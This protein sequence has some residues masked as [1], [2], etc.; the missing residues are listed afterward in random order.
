MSLLGQLTV[1]IMGSTAGYSGA[2]TAAQKAT[3]QFAKGIE[4]TGRNVSNFGKSLS[5]IG[6]SL[7]KKLTLPAVGAA[8]AL[9][10]ITLAKGWNRLVGIDTAKAKLIGLGHDADGVSKIMESALE[11]VKG[12]S[13]GM[14]EAATTAAS[15]VAAGIAPGKELTRYLSLTG[16]A[17]AIAGASMS[18]MGSIFN[19]V[20][21]SNKAYNDSLGQLS[22][23]GLPIYQ[24][25]AK[26][27]GVTEEAV[28]KM[29][30]EGKVS[31]EMFQAAIENNI[32]GAAK[33]MGENSF[34]ASLANMW[35]SVGR[36]G[37]N[38]LDAGG[39]GGGFFSTIKPMISDFTKNLGSIEEK[40]K[41]IGTKFG[42][43]FNGFITKIQEI[44]AKFDGLSPSMQDFIKKTALISAG[45]LVGIGP[46]IGIVGKLIMGIGGAITT[47]GKMTG[48]ISKLSVGIKGFGATIGFLTSPIGIA[49][50]SIT[51]LITI[52]V[53]LY[54]NWDTIK[55]KA[56]VV[57]TA[58]APL[59]ETVKGAFQN[60]MSSLGPIWESMKTLFESLL[61]ILEMVGIVVGGVIV[62]AFGIAISVFNAVVS[63]IGPLIN[64]IINIADIVTNM[65]NVVIALLTGDFAGAWEY[66]KKTGQSTKDFFVNI[67]KS[68]V[69]FI[70]T[71][72]KTIIDFFHGLYMTLVGNSIVPDIVNA[73]VKWFKDM[74]K[75]VVDLVKKIVDGVKQG[76]ENMKNAVQTVFNLLKTIITTALDY[77]LNT[78]RNILAFIKALVT[79][80]FE[81]M[82]NAVKN[83]MEN[84]LNTATRIFNA[85]KD[86]IAK[87][88]EKARDLISNAIDKIKGFFS[89]LKLKFPKIEMPSMPKITM[90]GSL[91]PADWVTKGLPKLKVNW[92]ALGGIFTKPTIFDTR[93]G[94]QGF[95]EAGPEA[96]LPLTKRVLGEIGQAI[97]QTMNQNAGSNQS[98]IVQP[99]PVMLDGRVIGEVVFDT[100][101]SNSYEKTTI[102]AY[103]RGVKV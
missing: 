16:D 77:W 54:K 74:A 70:S 32:G 37:A 64:A 68:I 47:F 24:W 28:F 98:I 93:A 73:I 96:I 22:D 89:G 49:L 18:D 94:L 4:N 69:N 33:S 29:A 14:D 86:A 20:Q 58:F 27:A 35:A 59:L 55:E 43:A 72:V 63:A 85:V 92:N 76:F 19:K 66:L 53:L 21:T 12:T 78:F 82:K 99:A 34:T 52:G 42:E 103:M 6:N 11:S 67:F 17:A 26:E 60:L 2:L 15:A 88:V 9:A 62:T 25:I 45:I 13:Y 31:A 75:W 65:V 84:I 87:P 46:A 48:L 44:K 79:G 81:G 57:F 100:I 56:Q 80:D 30:S 61:P 38:F 101:D 36:I 91:N 95:G 50:V 23:R 39:K 8:T 3:V 41:D 5:D 7:T 83:Q 51:A 1:G 40:A 102:N 71:F 10:G 97:A 90:T